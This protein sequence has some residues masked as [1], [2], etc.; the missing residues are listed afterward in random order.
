MG[1]KNFEFS[2]QFGHNEWGRQGGS[3]V[4][5]TSFVGNKN[6]YKI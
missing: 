3:I 1:L 5:T 4:E 6:P 2:K